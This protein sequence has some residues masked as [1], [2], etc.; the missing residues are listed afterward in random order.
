MAI[1]PAPVNEEVTFD[2]QDLDCIAAALDEAEDIWRDQAHDPH[3]E[4]Q[5]EYSDNADRA[6]RLLGKVEQL[7]HYLGGDTLHA[8]PRSPDGIVFAYSGKKEAAGEKHDIEC[9]LDGDCTCA[10]PPSFAARAARIGRLV[11]E[12][13]AAYGDSFSRSGEILERLY[14]N[15]IRPEQYRDALGVVR[16]IDK[17]FRI[18][19]KKDAFGESPW[20]DVAGYGV[21]AGGKE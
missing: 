3:E 5:K 9:D 21:V 2:E 13:N 4:N 20:D 18:A 7:A 12:K 11:D 1:A 14:P 6:R 16:V 8:K 17:L 19:T 15:G 10:A